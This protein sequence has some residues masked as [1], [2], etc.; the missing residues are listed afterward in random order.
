MQGS[1]IIVVLIFQELANDI[2]CWVC[3]KEFLAGQQISYC[4]TCPRSYHTRCIPNMEGM[5]PELTSPPGDLW[6]CPECRTID[7]AE[8]VLYRYLCPIMHKNLT[9]KIF[10]CSVN[11]TKKYYAPLTI[12][13]KELD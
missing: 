9:N 1:Y 12:C 6:A 2:Y 8:N 13:Y 7:R 3:H 4:K 11:I 5:T 10:K